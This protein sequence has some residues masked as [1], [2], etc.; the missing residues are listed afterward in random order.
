MVFCY[1]RYYSKEENNIFV[2][3]LQFSQF[4]GIGYKLYHP[5]GEEYDNLECPTDIYDVT[6]GDSS[7][8]TTYGYHKRCVHK[9]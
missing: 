1:S 5:P 8:F 9:W 3:I 7:R 2:K 6:V 4:T